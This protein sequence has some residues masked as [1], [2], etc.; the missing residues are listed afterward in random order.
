MPRNWYPE[1][2]DEHALDR[3]KVPQSLEYVLWDVPWTKRLYRVAREQET[4]KLV[5]TEHD[6]LAGRPYYPALTWSNESV[7]DH[8]GEWKA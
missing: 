8:I 2:P 5:Y 6:H 3:D 1:L 4:V 7:F